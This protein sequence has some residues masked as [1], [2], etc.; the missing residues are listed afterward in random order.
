MQSVPLPAPTLAEGA[1]FIGLLISI[2][3]FSILAPRFWHRR[4]GAIALFW[5]VTLLAPLALH[6]GVSGAFAE[7]WH[8]LLDEYLPF[9]S[10]LFVLYVGAGGILIRGGPGGT[11]LAN[12]LWLG[13][14]ALLA[15]VIGTTGAAM[16]LIRPLLHANA[17]RR[18]KFHL[19]LFF[20]LLVA[21]AGGALSPLGDPPLYLGFLEGVPFFWPLRHLLA[22]LVV[23]S[24]PLLGAFWLL[25]RRS[26]ARA[27]A[28]A[29]HRPFRLRG[30]GNFALIG[31][32]IAGV[33][34]QSVWRLGAVIL[35]GQPIAAEKL[36]A[37]LSF[38]ALGGLAAWTTPR[39]VHE[40][41]LFTWAPIAEVAQLFPAIFITITP[42]LALIA[43]GPAG[44]L[45]GFLRLATQ[46]DG[47]PSAPA[48]FWLTG[49]LAAFL[50]N[51]PTYLLFFRQAGID[52]AG[53][54]GGAGH[55]LR[56]ISAASV[57]FGGLTY[58]GNAPNMMVRTIAAHRGVRMPGFFGYMACAALALLPA[59]ALVSLI[60]FR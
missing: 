35:L 29:A 6:D 43:A 13:G 60:F 56:A 21:N 44:P 36:A 2:A 57:L 39:A 42:V 15:S 4:L 38:L 33:L 23:F 41:N 47:M 37:S 10:L 3:L 7:A 8:A 12:T 18:Q 28:P 1:P 11:P 31:L 25:D 34:A 9:I 16:V 40:A 55:V 26:A 53:L 51:A 59:L 46:A 45:A 24:A 27:A 20:I 50:D 32:V 30:W 49:L 54:D 48:Y 19:V 5:S 22:P 14:G 52:V 58:I 17:H